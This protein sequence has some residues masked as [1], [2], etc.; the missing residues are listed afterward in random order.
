MYHFCL[1][2]KVDC[3]YLQKP[4]VKGREKGD[5]QTREYCNFKG[6]ECA[7]KLLSPAC[8]LPSP[9]PPSPLLYLMFP[10]LPSSPSPSSSHS[11]TRVEVDPLSPAWMKVMRS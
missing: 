9:L 3:T 4:G 6:A 7:R 2:V 8:S 10:L 1:L 11:S 5:E